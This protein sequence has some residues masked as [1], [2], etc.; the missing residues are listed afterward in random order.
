MSDFKIIH[1]RP[2][3]IGCGVCAAI[4][5]EHWVMSNQDGKSNLVGSDEVGTDE[6]LEIDSLEKDMEAAQACPV[7]CI[8]L[9]EKEKKL[10]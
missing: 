1:D 9:Y 8:H 7:N 3:C 2:T 6:V 5:P 4:N 10:I